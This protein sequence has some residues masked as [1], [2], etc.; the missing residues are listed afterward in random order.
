VVE[1][2][3]GSVVTHVRGYAA[4]LTVKAGAGEGSAIGD[5]AYEA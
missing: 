1:H 4:S 5:A 3:R 2:V